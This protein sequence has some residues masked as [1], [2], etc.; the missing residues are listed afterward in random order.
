MPGATRSRSASRERRV[1]GEGRATTTE[2]DDPEDEQRM[3]RLPREVRAI[4]R[5][6]DKHEQASADTSA[7]LVAMQGEMSR[8]TQMLAVLF[9]TLPYAGAAAIAPSSL[10]SLAAKQTSTQSHLLSTPPPLSHVS[11]SPILEVTTPAPTPVTTLPTPPQFGALTPENLPHPTYPPKVTTFAPPTT[12][13]YTYTAPLVT[14]TT[15]NTTPPPIQHIHQVSNPNTNPHMYQHLPPSSI[16]NTS[17]QPYFPH[18]YHPP[19]NQ[20]QHLPPPQTPYTQPQPPQRFPTQP[21]NQPNYEVKPQGPGC[22][23]AKTF[24][25]WST[26][27]QSTG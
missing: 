19:F 26:S 9:T 1:R 10:P 4:R 12:P 11:L 7:A 5:R 3:A 18:Q 25:I 2:E 15:V 17:Q 13:M 22:L 8:M 23:N 27:Q 21:Q 16:P 24:W 14:T 20:P 6:L